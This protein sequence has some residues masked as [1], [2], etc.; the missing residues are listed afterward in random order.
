MPT[1][2]T[3]SQNDWF[4]PSMFTYDSIKSLIGG[5]SVY[6]RREDCAP[7]SKHRDSM[8]CHAIKESDPRL[9]GRDWASLRASNLTALGVETYG[10]FMVAQARLRPP[11]AVALTSIHCLMHA[12][13][14]TLGCSAQPCGDACCCAFCAWTVCSRVH[15]HGLAH[16]V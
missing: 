9:V 6:E 3:D 12:L 13:L 10:D 16:P 5:R 2:V 4:D 14:P 11:A 15:K 7:G 1:V 8:R